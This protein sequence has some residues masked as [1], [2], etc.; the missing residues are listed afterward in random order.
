MLRSGRSRTLEVK[1]S[2][3]RAGETTT[4]QALLRESSS[5]SSSRS[6]G[7]KAP[8]S[9]KRSTPQSDIDKPRKLT[10]TTHNVITNICSNKSPIPE[11]QHDP[12]STHT[13]QATTLNT[14]AI[15]CWTPAIGETELK[16]SQWVNFELETV[17]L[18][19]VFNCSAAASALLI[20]MMPTG[21]YTEVITKSRLSHFEFIRR[22]YLDLI[23][24]ACQQDK[25]CRNFGIFVVPY[26]PEKEVKETLDQFTKALARRRACDADGSSWSWVFDPAS[27]ALDLAAE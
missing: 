25:N 20:L 8:V 17:P 9:H 12:A 16:L 27:W 15:R 18:T 24:R 10:K 4:N 23:E 1:D 13:I 21:G 6:H 3:L 11:H 7:T 2:S 22:R 26:E 5:E 19:H 14:P